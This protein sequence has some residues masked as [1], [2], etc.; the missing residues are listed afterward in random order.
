MMGAFQVTSGKE[1]VKDR[2]SES[3]MSFKEMEMVERVGLLNAARWFQALEPGLQRQ[4]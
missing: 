1:R 2:K 4:I 3:A